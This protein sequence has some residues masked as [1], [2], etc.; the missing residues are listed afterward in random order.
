MT[1][2]GVPLL[3]AAARHAH[4]A[5]D[6]VGVQY[7]PSRIVEVSVDGTRWFAHFTVNEDEHARRA[8]SQLGA[9]TDTGLLHALWELPEDVPIP[10][11]ALADRD[12]A[13][14]RRDGE[15]Y[16]R[17]DGN[18]VERLF[19]PAGSVDTIAVVSNKAS[20]AVRSV[21]KLPP[22]YVR[23]AIAVDRRTPNRILEQARATGVGVLAISTDRPLVHVPPATAVRGVPAVY[24]WWIN[25]ITYRNWS[26]ANCAH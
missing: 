4:S 7:E 1:A 17:I 3:S 20:T 14:L 25:E 23:L 22:I 8:R 26:Y 2:P 16:V 6:A 21:G 11:Q 24:R 10:L 12:S 5:F 9:V 15:G 19:R 13:T 18:T